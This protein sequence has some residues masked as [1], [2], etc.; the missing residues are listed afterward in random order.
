MNMRIMAGVL[1]AGAAMAVVVDRIAVTV[2]N[3]AITE[4]EVIQDIRI[5]DFLNGAPLDFSPAARRAAAERLGG[6]AA[7]PRGKNNGGDPGHPH[8]GFLE[9]RAVG[10]QPRG[11]PRRRGAAGRSG[12]DPAR[13]EYR[14]LS[15]TA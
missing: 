5:T 12:A 11:S 1:L 2:D 3:D 15:P 6:Q 10:F 9:W 14:A 8:H 4:S 13:N 7:V